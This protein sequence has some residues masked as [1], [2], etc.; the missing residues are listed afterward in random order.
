[1]SKYL[2]LDLF[3]N[4]PWDDFYNFLTMG[5]P[6]LLLILLG[7]NT[8]FLLFFAT[9]KARHSPRLRPATLYWMQ[10]FM[11]AANGFV[12]FQKDILH[13]VMMARGII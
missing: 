12:I 13:Y 2:D 1:M 11:V 4:A 3:F 8:V 6:S 9:R 10:A 7:L 5:S